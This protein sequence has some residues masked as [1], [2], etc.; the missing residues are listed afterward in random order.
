MKKQHFFL[1]I[2]NLNSLM[3][4]VTNFHLCNCFNSLS[5]LLPVCSFT[6]SDENGLRAEVGFMYIKRIVVFT[7]SFVLIF[8]EHI[9]RQTF[10]YKINV[11]LK[12][13]WIYRSFYF[14]YYFRLIFI[15]RVAHFNDKFTYCDTF[16]TIMYQVGI[17]T[18]ITL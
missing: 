7:A 15:Q 12:S 8:L 18:M 10:L 1:V 3:D 11:L 13:G 9:N 14:R 4:F 5:Q 6:R 16:C 17:T 2:V